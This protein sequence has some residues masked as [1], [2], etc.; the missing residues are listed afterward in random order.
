MAL[1]LCAGDE[2]Q[3]PCPHLHQGGKHPALHRSRQRKW[4][5]AFALTPALL[6]IQGTPLYMAPELVKEQP[7][8]HT[9]DLWSLGCI[10]YELV[11]SKPPFYTNNIFQVGCST[12]SLPLCIANQPK[13]T[14]PYTFLFCYHQQLVN[15]IVKDPIQYPK[16]I[17]P[18][19]K[20]C[21]EGG[22][23]KPL[24]RL[25]TPTSPTP[26]HSRLPQ[27]FLSGLLNK[28]PRK[29]LA[30][31]DVELHPFLRLREGELAA[32]T[33]TP[34]A[35]PRSAASA[36]QRAAAAV[37]PPAMQQRRPG[38]PPEDWKR[39]VKATAP[40]AGV[41][42]LHAIATLRSDTACMAALE[43]AILAMPSAILSS[44]SDYLPM[45]AVTANLLA[46]DR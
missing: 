3:H 18:E 42:R 33:T 19:F 23:A 26:P 5:N 46:P 34:S 13:R 4:C 35:S 12:D 6:V 1:K 29:R 37:P 43:D 22:W 41:A 9:A 2:R 36:T 20:V 10:L 7:Y 8:D 11:V 45:L 17:D 25:H 30:W 21:T 44:T 32:P 31:P 14:A 40:A 28:S 27:S 24:F 16:D 38:A 39:H 15:Q